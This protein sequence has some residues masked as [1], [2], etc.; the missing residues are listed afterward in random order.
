[1][2]IREVGDPRISPDGAW[3]A[4]TVRRRDPKEDKTDRDVYMVSWDGARTVR[5]TTSKEKEHT[6]RWSPD[7]QYLAFLSSRDA[8]AET[9]QI[10]LLNRAGGEAERITDFEGGVEDYAWSPDGRRLAVIAEDPDPEAAAKGQDEKKTSKPIVIDRY[11]FKQD[12]TGYLTRT[13]QHLYLFDV[14]SR[15]AD[16]LTPGE[17]N[18]ALPSWSPDGTSIAFV[19]K[20]GPDFDRHENYDIYMIEAKVGATP[21][22][23]TTHPDADSHPEWESRPEWSPDGK[24]IVYLQGGPQKLIYYAVWKLAVVPAGGGTPRLLAPDLDRNVTRPRWSADG[25]SIYFLL[26]DDRSAHLARVPVAGG[27]VERV[28]GGNRV[29]DAFD[30]GPG[31]RAAILVGT[32]DGPSEVFALQPGSDPRPLSRQNQAL[33]SRLRLGP[34]EEISVRSKDGTT[35]NGCLVKP[36]DFTPGTRYPTLL[37]IHGGPAA[38]FGHEFAFDWQFFASRGYVVVGVNPRGSSGRGEAFSR[39]IY[40]EWGR[41]DA[42]DVLA[43]VDH[44]VAKGIADPGRLVVGGWSYGGMLTNYVIAQ[45]ARFKAAVSGAG[46][47]NIL[48]GY[49]TDQYIREYEEELGPPW[50]NLETWMRVS[51]PFLHADRIVTPTLFLCGD[52][53]FNVPLLNSEQMYQALRSLGRDTQLVIYPGQYHGLTRPSY[54][55]DRL[56]RSLAWYEKHIRAAA[57]PP[58]IRAEAP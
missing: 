5:L 10:W 6:P 40:A 21:R 9:D 27:K 1:V 50:R 47:S 49:G 4:Y 15:R 52:K 28:V 34:A 43:A 35:V 22:Q 57:P 3:V 20:R 38:Q 44:L 12:E 30:L 13:R 29:I 24:S 25:S 31:D 45:D 36:P 14:A 23:I 53:D 46:I 26:E 18:E 11:Q 41:K 32:H 33:L 58:S 19:S 16:I 37:R 55:R 8:A 39:A 54:E 7:G 42:Q 2:E 17:F 48:A 56:E 51:F